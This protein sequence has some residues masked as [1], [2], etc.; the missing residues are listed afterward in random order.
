[1]SGGTFDYRQSRIR[2]ISEAIEEIIRNN[3]KDNRFFSKDTIKEFRKGVSVLKKAAVYAQ[4]IDYLVA[5]DDG[6]EAFHERLKE[7]LGKL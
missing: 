3:I 6:E 2:D 4:R 1:M 5:G 7:D